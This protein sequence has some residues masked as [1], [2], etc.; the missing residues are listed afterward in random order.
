MGKVARENEHTKE[1]F[2]ANHFKVRLCEETTSKLFKFFD[3]EYTA[4]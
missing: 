1:N 3:S 2:W 4:A